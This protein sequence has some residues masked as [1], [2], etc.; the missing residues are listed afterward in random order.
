MKSKSLFITSLFLLFQLLG[1]SAA[2][3]MQAQM[4]IKGKFAD[5]AAEGMELTVFC[6]SDYYSILSPLDRAAKY[7]ARIKGGKFQLTL[8]AVKPFSY[9]SFLFG[10]ADKW[11]SAPSWGL[12][13]RLYLVESE[14]LIEMDIT[15][16][17]CTFSERNPLLKAQYKMYEH[18]Y[19]SPI[20]IEEQPEGELATMNRTMAKTLDLYV[21]Q[22]KILGEYEGSISEKA[23]AIL[24]LDFFGDHSGNDL[25]N[26]NF[27]PN[28]P[29][30]DEVFNVEYVPNKAENERVNKARLQYYID[31]Y[32]FLNYDTSGADN[33]VYSRSYVPFLFRKLLND[34]GITMFATS[35][36]LWPTF[37]QMMDKISQSYSGPLKEKLMAH[38]FINYSDMRSEPTAMDFAV[39]GKEISIPE[40][41]KVVDRTKKQKGIGQAAY[42]FQLKDSSGKTFT[43]ESLK[44]KVVV[45]DFWFTG[46]GGCAHLNKEMA[47]VYDHYKNNP[48]VVFVTIS[49]DKDMELWKKKGLGS[50]F[51]SH[52]GA[53]DLYTNGSGDK[54]PILDYYGV[55][56]FPTLIIID[57][58]GKV[59]TRNPPRGVSTALRN[60]FMAMVDQCLLG[61]NKAS[62]ETPANTA[63]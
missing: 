22:L 9:I 49:I 33:K 55:M 39:A 51:Y 47:P 52:K 27:L 54:H 23:A 31:N 3:Q 10:D 5:P 61:G 44:G 25:S 40:Y 2:S 59:V 7:T 63:F 43:Q 48:N 8:P 17:D 57:K 62:Q 38:A 42:N 12:L 35:Q 24:K 26:I 36:S 28:E 56:E 18:A 53:V 50:G 13:Q 58:E 41:R 20:L 19:K 16:D 30:R 29:F 4:V 1:G 34:V 14:S 37:A 32:F 60:R 15:K 11:G 46:C 45:L 6:C 21:E